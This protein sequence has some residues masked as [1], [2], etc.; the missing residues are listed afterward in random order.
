MNRKPRLLLSVLAGLVEA[1][2]NVAVN[3]ATEWK[4]NPWA[5]VAV[6]VLA[7]VVAWL[8][9]LVSQGGENKTTDHQGQQDPPVLRWEERN[10][11]ARRM[12]STTS[13][14]VATEFLRHVPP[15]LTSPHESSRSQP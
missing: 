15:P 9:Y 1:A 14:T 13:E 7:M 5:W 3:L 11:S 6:P 10:G 12:V 4:H 2:L 8:T